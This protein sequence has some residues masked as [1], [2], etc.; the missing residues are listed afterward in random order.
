V[1]A[2][3]LHPDMIIMDVNMPVLNGIEATRM[4]AEALPE[5]RVIGLSMHSE[6]GIAEQMRA[7][8]A[9]NRFLKDGPVEELLAAIQSQLDLI[10][11]TDNIGS[12]C[13]AKISTI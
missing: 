4:I 9:I 7:A 8:G 6:G 10:S 2:M 13:P 11:R 5:T 12:N 1:F 3:Q